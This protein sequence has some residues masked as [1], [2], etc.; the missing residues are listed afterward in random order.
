M[1]RWW[2]CECCVNV[3]PFSTMPWRVGCTCLRCVHNNRSVAIT[4]RTT[5]ASS[6]AEI[7]VSSPQFHYLKKH[8]LDQS[9]QKKMWFNFEKR[10]TENNP[11]GVPIGSRTAHNEQCFCF[12]VQTRCYTDQSI[13]ETACFWDTLML[14]I[15]LS[16][17][18]ST[19]FSCD[20]T[21]VLDNTKSLV[22][23]KVQK[24]ITIVYCIL[25]S[26]NSFGSN[27]GELD[28]IH[29]LE[30]RSLFK[31]E[32]SQR[33]NGDSSSVIE[34]APFYGLGRRILFSVQEQVKKHYV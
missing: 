10:G 11:T 5:I 4:C 25:W 2:W 28:H 26:K 20:L 24:L 15:C 21:D 18:K 3:R 34:L 6:L 17:V 23:N 30:D 22:V 8:F 14:K 9:I 31:Q 19:L 7:S 16:E 12:R 33:L 27:Y 13:P 1:C 32:R 29:C